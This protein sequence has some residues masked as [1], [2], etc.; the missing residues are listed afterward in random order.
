MA[1]TS[2]GENTSIPLSP[3]SQSIT[4]TSLP[5]EIL[6]NILTHVSHLPSKPQERNR[7]L[8]AI[9]LTARAL[10]YEPEREL[11]R[12]VKVHGIEDVMTLGTALNPFTQERVGR[13]ASFVRHLI[14]E[15]S[16]QDA[17]SWE[18]ISATLRLVAN[19]QTLTIITPSAL[20]PSLMTNSNIVSKNIRSLT[21]P[22]APTRSLA[23]V[24]ASQSRMVHLSLTPSS[25]ILTAPMESSDEITLG[26]FIKLL[27]PEVLPSLTSLRTPCTSLA[28]A[29]ILHRPLERLWTSLPSVPS[30]SPPSYFADPKY[31]SPTHPRM[32]EPVDSFV[33][34][35]TL[36]TRPLHVLHFTFPKSHSTNTGAFTAFLAYLATSN[37]SM[38]SLGIIP[39][40]SILPLVSPHVHSPLNSLPKS[41]FPFL[42]SLV[43][44]SEPSPLTIF[45]LAQQIPSLRRVI[46]G[47]FTT[48]EEYLCTPVN[49]GVGNEVARGM[50][51]EDVWRAIGAGF[52]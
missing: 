41:N 47:V 21:V 36:S 46:C 27:T 35:L 49:D 3:K 28:T 16:F 37:P 13:T 50:T 5:P 22:F 38:T 2:S 32:P 11:Y 40:S 19:L 43:L 33:A 51:E 30:T 52:L 18:V 31:V 9:A 6:A 15:G 8:C 42:E 12:V 7:T 48:T 34:S 39:P 29:L 45:H 1:A 25:H 4:L 10:N 26:D 17:C 44:S 24:L 14:V 20:P 23:A